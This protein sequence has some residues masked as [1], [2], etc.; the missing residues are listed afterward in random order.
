MKPKIKA[1]L[2][3]VL[4]VVLSVPAL[5]AES[6]AYVPDLTSA[7]FWQHAVIYVAQVTNTNFFKAEDDEDLGFGIGSPTGT[8][9]YHIIESI[10]GLASQGDRTVSASGSHLW[11]GWPYEKG[12]NN[13]IKK[14]EYILVFED[15]PYKGSRVI[16]IIVSPEKE[17]LVN[18]LKTISRLNATGSQDD[19]LESAVTGDDLVTKYALLRLL[20]ALNNK[21]ASSDNRQKLQ[22]VADDPKRDATIRILA[23]RVALRL[24]GR[25]DNSDAEYSF[26]TKAFASHETKEWRQLGPFVDR[27]LDLDDKRNEAIPFLLHYLTD[28]NED[29][30]A[31]FQIG[32]PRIQQRTRL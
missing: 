29:F 11:P 20:A 27:L 8:F 30:A 1:C 31:R 7:S 16:K 19:L 4:G 18:S 28:E 2:V 23:E 13:E 3:L 25:A 15:Q 10:A 26:L 14:G 21:D 12:K 9:S 24:S 17:P 32:A 22:A 5:G 6:P